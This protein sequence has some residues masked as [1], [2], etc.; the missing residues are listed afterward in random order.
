[1]NGIDNPII[2]YPSAIL[3][4]LFAILSI[5]VK[6]IFRSL[7]CAIAVFFFA[8]LFFY[9]L[10]SEYNAVI[11]IAIYGVAVPVILGL[12]I[13]FTNHK[14]KE[15]IKQ[16]NSKYIIF[17]IS[18]LFILTTVYLILTSFAILPN[19]FN[20]SEQIGGSSFQTLSAISSGIFV[21]YVWAFELISLILT[22]IVVG[23]TLLTKK[24]EN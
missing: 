5:G 8:G 19:S 14:N 20:F 15:I 17:L 3:I 7:I 9:I 6:D 13:M 4:I 12:A 23:L 2:F 10:G 16:T 22:I 11:Q 18:G 1:V 24:E 21:N